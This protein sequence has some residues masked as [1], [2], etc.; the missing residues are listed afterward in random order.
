MQ[1]A[2]TDK[3]TQNTV[4]R[5]PYIKLD[6]LCFAHKTKLIYIYKLLYQTTNPNTKDV[7]KCFLGF[8]ISQRKF[9]QSIRKY[10]IRVQKYL[11]SFA[12]TLSRVGF[13]K[14]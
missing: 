4:H 5:G 7:Y 13:G 1:K 3:N 2:T 11:L 6:T 9:T 10:H 12:G 14:I 8:R